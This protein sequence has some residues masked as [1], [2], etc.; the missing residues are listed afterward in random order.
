MFRVR[1]VLYINNSLALSLFLV[2]RAQNR[3]YFLDHLVRVERLGNRIIGAKL[4]G[5]LDDIGLGGE[6]DYRYL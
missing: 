6:Y 3:P 1:P 5:G 4:N 2:G